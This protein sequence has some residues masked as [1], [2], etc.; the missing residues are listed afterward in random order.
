MKRSRPCWTGRAASAGGSAPMLRDRQNS[1]APIDPRQA[2]RQALLREAGVTARP[3][4]QIPRRHGTSPVPLSFAQQRLWFIDQWEPASA[5]Y[6]VPTTVRLTGNIDV[7]AVERSLNEIVRRHEALRTTFTTVDDRPVQVIGSFVETALPVIDLQYL[8]ENEREAAALKLATSEAQRPFDL[9]CWPLFRFKLFRL[10]PDVHILQWTLHHIV[11]DGWTSGVL[12]REFGSLYEAFNAGLSSPLPD[13][14]IQ[15]GDY[16]VWQREWL[17]GDTLDRLL[18]YWKQRLA[19]AP[20]VLELPA[21]RPRPA[22]QTFRG[23]L[24]RLE[25]SEALTRGIRELSRKEGATLFMTL[26]A[27]FQTLVFRYTGQTDCVVGSPLAN[28]S[29][30]ET[31]RLIGCFFNTL[32]FRTD[33]SGDP[34]FRQLLARVREIAIEADAHQ[35]LPFEKLVE[36]LRPERDLSHAPL[37]QIAFLLGAPPTS[38]ELPDLTITPIEIDRETAKFDLGVS[39]VE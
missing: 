18:T 33:L 3:I 37:V 11:S 19:G 29:R 14:P 38:L 8:D 21:D 1:D 32:V 28:R 7:A 2:L 20:A 34:S 6:N 24:A 31:E 15:Y 23:G 26:L 13:L 12:I 27:A 5:L 39:V 10:D 22:I 4:A 35:D 36:A 9:A 17:Q 30:M 16:A 25:L